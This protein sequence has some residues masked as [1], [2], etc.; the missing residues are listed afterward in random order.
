MLTEIRMDSV[1]SFKK[2]AKLATDKRINL[3]YGLNGTGKSTISNFLY[4]PDNTRFIKCGKLPALSD[5]VLVYNQS[6]IQDNFYIADSLK[7]IFSLSKEN[8]SAE[9]KIAKASAKLT[10]LEQS[11]NAQRAK[12][13]E[14]TG[15]LKSKSRRLSTRFGK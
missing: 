12:K 6:F 8:K 14:V 3:V 9:E 13:Q 1:A 10:E 4:E 5:P 11:Q 15:N 7:G 2:E